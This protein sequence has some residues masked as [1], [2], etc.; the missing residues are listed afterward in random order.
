MVPGDLFILSS[1]VYFVLY[2][3]CALQVVAIFFLHMCP[4]GHFIL[5]YRLNEACPA[6]LYNFLI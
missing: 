4:I 5:V 3:E 2:L 6:K 1:A